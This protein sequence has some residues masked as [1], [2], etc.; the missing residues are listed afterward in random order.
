MV[1][2]LAL[3]KDSLHNRGITLV[4]PLDARQWTHGEHPLEQ[5]GARHFSEVEQA[6]TNSEPLLAG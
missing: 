3:L 1:G 2:A 4:V 5:N 6:P